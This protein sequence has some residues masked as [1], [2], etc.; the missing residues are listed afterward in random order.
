MIS[1]HALPLTVANH[2][3][4]RDKTTVYDDFQ[5]HIDIEASNHRKSRDKTT[6]YDDFQPHIDIESL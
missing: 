2:R 6:V 3:K 1:S 5:P 4:T